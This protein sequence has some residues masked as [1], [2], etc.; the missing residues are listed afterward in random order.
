MGLY[1]ASGEWRRVMSE[2]SFA[3]MS[4]TELTHVFMGTRVP[5]S[6][7]QG[8][9]LRSA[10]GIQG[11]DVAKFGGD[12]W[13][14]GSGVVRTLANPEAMEIASDKTGEPVEPEDP[15]APEDPGEEPSEPVDPPSSTIPKVIFSTDCAG[16]VDDLLAMAE[17]FT[18][19]REGKIDIVALMASASTDYQAPFLRT[20]A[21]I[22]GLA[23][24][25]LGA[26]QGGNAIPNDDTYTRELSQLFG[27]G[28]VKRDTLPRART[29]YRQVL[30]S[31][32]KGEKVSICIIGFLTDLA[33]LITSRD[34]DDGVAGSGEKIFAER[35][36]RIVTQGTLN[37]EST[38]LAANW[39]KNVEATAA[40]FNRASDLGVPVIVKPSDEAR[41]ILSGPPAA[42]Q[43]HS[44]PLTLGWF[45]RETVTRPSYDSMAL[46]YMLGTKPRNWKTTH[47]NISVNI[48]ANRRQFTYDTGKPGT[49]TFI[50]T[51]VSDSAFTDD[52]NRLSAASDVNSYAFPQY[53]LARHDTAYN[54]T[55]PATPGIRTS[56]SKMPGRDG[57]QF[58]L[59]GRT[60]SLGRK[61]G[62]SPSDANRDGVY[63]AELRQTGT[64]YTAKQFARVKVMPDVSRMNLSDAL[65]AKSNDYDIWLGDDIGAFFQDRS[66]SPSRPASVGDRVGAWVGAHAGLVFIADSNAKRPVLRANPDVPGTY[67]LQFS[68]GQSMQCPSMT[69]MDASAGGHYVGAAYEVTGT[70]PGFVFRDAHANSDPRR[71]GCA[72]GVNLEGDGNDGVFT[73]RKL[74][75][76]L[77]RPV[78]PTVTLA[79]WSA[80][81]RVGDIV[82]NTGG[83]RTFKIGDT[84]QRGSMRLGGSSRGQYLTGFISGFV[85]SKTSLS[86]SRMEYFRQRLAA[87]NKAPI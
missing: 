14:K 49:F 1:I 68:G 56:L 63:E 59:S 86:D 51:A 84:G 69:E 58:S 57:A 33:D 53:H 12:V 42:W 35:I 27:V 15:I 30:S 52:M 20:C 70:A 40:V 6:N 5:D 10:Y 76:V 11:F 41:N 18:A 64:R 66:S 81:A 17:A 37:L 26:Y 7:E 21:D 24:V 44:N 19:H 80:D 50:E 36:E 43:R 39:G 85:A 47:R 87:Q 45:M 55:V 67:R 71:L 46:H 78:G 28:D 62:G 3:L 13:I 60:V 25:P 34:G 75:S 4:T 8:V 22:F 32:P 9:P 73:V 16:D 54:F 29:V 74:S 82:Q 48:D 61:N 65:G 2:T 23:D 77:P 83:F 79:G 31:L 72:L 38:E